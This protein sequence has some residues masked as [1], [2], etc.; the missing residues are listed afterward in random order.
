MIEYRSFRNGDPP[1]I[2]ALW[3]AGGLGR[4]AAEPLST[5]AFE[6]V[7]FSQTFFDLD[8][9]IVACDG[10]RIVGFAH[11][12]F[13]PN[14]NRTALSYEV[15][16]LCAVLVHPEYRGQGIGAEL[17]RRAETFLRSRGAVEARAGSVTP[18]DPFYVGIYGGVQPAGCLVSD[19]QAAPFF[20]ALGYQ[21][22]SRHRIYQR[23]I[24]ESGPPVHFR[25]MALR[26]KT[27]LAVI[28]GPLNRS[29]W[30]NTRY[31]RLDWIRFALIVKGETTP[32]ASATVVGLDFYVAKWGQRSVGL[33][34]LQIHAP[35]GDQ[36]YGE[37]LIAEISKRLRQELV[38]L[39]EVHAADE[40]SQ[41][42]EMIE[43]AGFSPVDTGTVL[44]KSLE[45]SPTG[46]TAE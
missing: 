18:L 33:I 13:G 20:S 19:A 39:V 45:G 17:V 2:V 40:D 25:L 29:W 27:Q 37:I 7:N 31:G 24:A 23:N 5:D 38:T 36:G 6:I 26:R 43:S 12:G 3:N 46:G 11:A 4:G 21:P 41:R 22:L 1:Q 28:D 34:D 14:E 9:L 8:G 30:W 44:I 10:D 32:L 42:I 35:D 16:V 15:G